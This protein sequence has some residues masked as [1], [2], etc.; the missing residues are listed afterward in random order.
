ML[1]HR[2]AR[3]CSSGDMS[4]SR[5]RSYPPPYLGGA[6]PLARTLSRALPSGDE[7]M[8]NGSTSGPDPPG[9]CPGGG[10]VKSERKPFQALPS[11]PAQVREMTMMSRVSGMAAA[12]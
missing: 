3:P 7:V 1:N 11:S 5:L 12:Q 2:N 4:R 9:A 10:G 8:G 6:Y